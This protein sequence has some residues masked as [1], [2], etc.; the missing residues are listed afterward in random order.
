MNETRRNASLF[1]LLIDES[2]FYAE[3]ENSG[4]IKAA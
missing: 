1:L 4:I 3:Q 2:S